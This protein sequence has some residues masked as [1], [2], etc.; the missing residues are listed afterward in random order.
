MCLVGNPN[1]PKL[2]GALQPKGNFLK[3]RWVMQDDG[4]SPVLHYLVRYKPVS[5][6][7]RAEM[8]SPHQLLLINGPSVRPILW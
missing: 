2:E 4:G 1:P 7:V 5:M 6:A 8:I 3:V